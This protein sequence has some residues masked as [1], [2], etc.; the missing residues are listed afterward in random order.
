MNQDIVQ[1]VRRQ[2]LEDVRRQFEVE[3][4][5]FDQRLADHE[6][7]I[8]TLG[9]KVRRIGSITENCED[10]W[11]RVR[12][13]LND[14]EAR[15]GAGGGNGGG[16]GGGAGGRDNANQR[17]R[18]Q[19]CSKRPRDLT[20]HHNFISRCTKAHARERARY[21]RPR[22]ECEIY[23]IPCRELYYFSHNSYK[24]L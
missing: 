8:A 22:R 17:P 6:N 16:N 3:R 10:C 24:N 4:R 15:G 7:R 11:P 21:Q 12:P 20:A 9:D 13:M 14:Q 5:V 18:C 1:E 19:Y 2:V 23:R